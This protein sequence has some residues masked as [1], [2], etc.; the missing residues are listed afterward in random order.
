MSKDE[1]SGYMPRPDTMPGRVVA[2][3]AHN[4]DE[5]LTAKDISLKFAVGANNVPAN[6]KM[7]LDAKLLVRV[8]DDNLEWVYKPGPRIPG[9][10][11]VAEPTAAGD[12]GSLPAWPH[13]PT[14]DAPKKRRSY[15]AVA[16]DPN[17]VP[18]EEGVPLTEPKRGSTEVWQTLLARMKPGHSCVLPVVKIAQVKKAVTSATKSGNGKFAVRRLDD[19]QSLRLWRTE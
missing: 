9:A 10:D 11:Q 2:W 15:T 3:F 19:G 16:I 13:A 4:P 6:L 14:S 18:L 12:S 1:P 7:A 5:T 17:A 8:R